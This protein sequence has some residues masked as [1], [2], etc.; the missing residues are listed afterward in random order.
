MSTLDQETFAARVRGILCEE[1]GLPAD[2]VR[3]NTV[4]KEIP[5]IE[6]LRV[7]R[8]VVKLERTFDVELEDEAVFDLDTVADLTDVLYRKINTRV[9]TP[10]N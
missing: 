10:V 4:L 2:E 5:G 6:S 8:L 3:D 9:D 7:L 1:F